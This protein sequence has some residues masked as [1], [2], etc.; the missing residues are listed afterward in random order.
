L[1]DQ[2]ED[3]MDLW[4]IQE[5]ETLAQCGGI[6]VCPAPCSTPQRSPSKD[7]VGPGEKLNLSDTLKL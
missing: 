5:R 1:K 2:F 3:R 6:D 4:R 7:D